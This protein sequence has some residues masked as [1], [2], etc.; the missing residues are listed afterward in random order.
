MRN[1][2]KRRLPHIHTFVEQIDDNM[3]A[4]AAY[5]YE[6]RRRH[7]WIG[8]HYGVRRYLYGLSCFVLVE[9]GN[10]DCWPRAE[11]AAYHRLLVLV[12]GGLKFIGPAEGVEDT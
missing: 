3:L 8:H 11:R 5:C 9:R 7:E 4:G 1:G 6:I 2:R 12:E 10:R